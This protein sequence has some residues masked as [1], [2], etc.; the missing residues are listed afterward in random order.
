MKSGVKTSEFYV[1]L[2]VVAPW[3]LSQ[4]GIDLG[5]VITDADQLRAVIQEAH[6]GSDLPVWVA[7]AF[8]IGRPLLKWKLGK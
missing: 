5:A 2:A 6:K 3:L 4:L 7:G 1:V 8:V